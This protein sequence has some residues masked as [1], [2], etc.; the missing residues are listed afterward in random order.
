[1]SDNSQYETR[2]IFDVNVPFFVRG[3]TRMNLA[4]M[5]GDILE[6][7]SMLL[8]MY[9]YGVF[10]V[11]LTPTRVSVRERNAVWYFQSADFQMQ[12]T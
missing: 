6:R 8:C 5:L 7:A 2:I 4:P 12:I 11:L 3:T 9:V 1:M 10:Y